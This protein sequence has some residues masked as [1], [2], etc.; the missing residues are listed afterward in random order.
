V[1]EIDSNIIVAS[2]LE[3]KLVKSLVEIEKEI[4]AALEK[5]LRKFDIKDGQFIPDDQSRQILATINKEIRK[6]VDRVAIEDEVM[7]F[8]DDFDLIDK[9]ISAIQNSLNGIRVEK[10]IFTDQK[11]WAVDATVNSLVQAN[12]DLKFI[13]PVKQLLYSRVSFGGSVVDAERQLK[14]IVLGDV[15]K[16]GVL[17]RW[18]GQIARD[19]INEYQG[20]IN[21]Q[22]KVQYDLNAVRYIGGLVEDSRAQCVRWVKEFGGVLRDDQL[23]SEIEWAY[24]NGSG[25]KP[26]T[27]P[28]NF[29]QKRGGYNCNHDAIPVRRK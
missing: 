27:N 26:D 7:K 23:A 1:P 5:V 2:R 24:K 22:I 6:I 12:I 3:K 29:C 19:T 9:N 25:M 4:F 15:G 20:T 17:Q 8:I 28:S 10:S 13:Q 16:Y 11:Q 21:Q 18:I 14:Q